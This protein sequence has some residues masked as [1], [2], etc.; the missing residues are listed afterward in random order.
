MTNTPEPN[1]R[2]AV[3]L[4]SKA[5]AL[6]IRS[7]A[8]HT[9]RTTSSLVIYLLESALMEAMDAGQ[10]PASAMQEMTRYMF[11]TRP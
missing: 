5:Q 7:W 6:L 10:I 3:S 9:G 4:P 8:E 11:E 1:T 2:F